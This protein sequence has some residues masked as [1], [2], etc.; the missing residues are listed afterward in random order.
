[1]TIDEMADLALK[2]AQKAKDYVD[3]LNTFSAH[4]VMNMLTTP[5]IEIAEDGLTAQGVWFT[6]N[7]MSH[8]DKS[9]I[10]QPTVNAGK[11]CAEFVKEQGAWKLWRF[12][13][14]PNGFDLDV[15]LKNTGLDPESDEEDRRKMSF[16]M[17][18]P[19]EEERKLM[20]HRELRGNMFNPEVMRYTPW[21]PTEN[22]PPLPEPYRTY[23]EAQ[24]FF[25]FEDE[26]N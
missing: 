24:P 3:I 2:K 18:K 23:S 4:R 19:S 20:H 12:R 8:L 6:F 14:C 7:I 21:N 9:G 11:T 13:G 22:D 25:E 5:F 26:D 10:P 17:P 15:K 1:M 16:G